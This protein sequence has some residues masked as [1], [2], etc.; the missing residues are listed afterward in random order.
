ML[1]NNFFTFLK[2]LSKNNNKDWFDIHRQ[3][4]EVDV[5]K[6][7]RTFRAGIRKCFGPLRW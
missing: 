4:Y 7:I 5:K 2:D 3:R 1:T 6:A